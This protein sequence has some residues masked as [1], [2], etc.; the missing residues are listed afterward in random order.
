MADAQAKMT[1]VATD[2]SNSRTNSRYAS[3]A[4]LDRHLR[5]IY[6]ELG[7]A[8]SF[9]SGDAPEGTVKVL[10]HVS[11]R[12]GHTRTYSAM[13]PADGKGAKGGDVMSKTHAV[14]SA[15]TYGQRY[16]LK[17][18]FNVAVGTDDDG[19]AASGVITTEQKDELVM[20]LR[21]TDSDTGK[22]L[23]VYGVASIDELLAA[24]YGAA[25]AMLEQ[26]RQKAGAA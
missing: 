5:P 10:C 4:A 20:L 9:D 11:H 24:N 1:R 6:S 16:L 15:F 12:G 26:K 25:K 13:M 21:E 23:A 8:L 14:G 19:N 3:Y 22:L 7:F 2:Q 17:M 18:I